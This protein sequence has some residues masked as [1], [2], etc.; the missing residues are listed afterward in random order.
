MRA[1]VVLDDAV[2]RSGAVVEKAIVDVGT[3]VS[4]GDAGSRDD[5]SGVVIFAAGG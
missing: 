4:A 3:V 2:I 5:A 1:S